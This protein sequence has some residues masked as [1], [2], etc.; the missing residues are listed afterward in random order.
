MTKAHPSMPP[1]IGGRY[2][3]SCDGDIEWRYVIAERCVRKLLLLL[4]LL[5]GL[6]VA[7]EDHDGAYGMEEKLLVPRRVVVVELSKN[8]GWRREKELSMTVYVDRERLST[9][10]M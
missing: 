8:R 1:D 10:I 7:N 3:S 5:L 6:A 9:T 4:L 2:G